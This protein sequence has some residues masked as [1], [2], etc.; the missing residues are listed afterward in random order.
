MSNFYA[1]DLF[2]KQAIDALSRQ[3][4]GR[5][6]CIMPRPWAWLV[7]LIATIFVVALLFLSAAEF[8]RKETVRG[9]LVSKEGVVRI[10]HDAA[11]RITRVVHKP[12][13]KVRKGEPL[14]FMSTDS[15]LANGVNKNEHLLEKIHE[16]IS[17][18]DVQQ[19]LLHQQL[20]LDLASVGEQLRNIDV[21]RQSLSAQW[22]EQRRVVE[23]GLQKLDRLRKAASG[24]AVS[25][26][27][28]LQQRG[29]LATLR[30]E[31]SRLE[32][33]TAMLQRERELLQSR[34]G[35][36]PVQA[37]IR[38]S[39]LRLQKMRLLQQVAEYES[40]RLT[41]L[42]SPLDG[43]IAVSVVRAGNTVAPQQL[44]MTILPADMSLLAEV[45]VP[46]SAMGFVHRGQVVRLTYDALPQQ[47]FGTFEGIVDHVSEFVLLPAEIPQT[48]L[49]REA[50][51]KVQ[52]QI[53]DEIIITSIGSTRLRPGMLLAAE[54]V[55]ERR[56][57]L[58]WLLEPLHI[59]RSGST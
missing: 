7:V 41:V 38:L 5:P 31:L 10:A 47:K 48:F 33:D 1:E 2:R 59:R 29:E 45:Y 32:R 43:T 13:D 8:S 4:L 17:E 25:E 24:G 26:W 58:D 54:I 40:R 21:E 27:D 28:L 12:G 36:L 6:I 42:K 3:P 30:Q 14:L 20:G 52:V 16:E 15:T 22:R 53:L 57:L 44:L 37:E 35:G 46:S 49:V 56:N 19:N 18:I 55:M 51:Y 11:A 34:S 9:W 39:D 23:F 50:T